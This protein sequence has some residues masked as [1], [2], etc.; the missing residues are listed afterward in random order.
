LAGLGFAFAGCG[1]PWLSKT[2]QGPTVSQA[3]QDLTGSQGRVSIALVCATEATLGI[4]ISSGTFRNTGF[5][6]EKW[7][8]SVCRDTLDSVEQWMLSQFGSRKN[9]SLVDRFATAKLVAETN[10]STGTTLSPELRSE[11]GLRSGATHV[12]FIEETINE[13]DGALYRKIT[14]IRESRLLDVP[15]GTVVAVETRKYVTRRPY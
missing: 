4:P 15:T 5:T 7:K 10:S 1:L 8:Q 14:E 12:L 6:V 2:P 3:L 13:F 11:L 9:F